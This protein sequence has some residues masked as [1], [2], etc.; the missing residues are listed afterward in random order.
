MKEEALVV[1]NEL[2]SGLQTTHIRN[3]VIRMLLEMG[4]VDDALKVLDEMLDPEA[5]F[6]AD[7]LTVDVVIGLLLRREQIGRSVSEEEIVE[8]VS[9]FGE[10][11]VFPNIVLLTKLVSVLCRNRKVDLA[12]DF[13][14]DVMKMGGAVEAVSC[15]ALLT[16]LGRGNDFERMNA[17]TVKMKE[18]GIKPSVITFGILI[19]RFCKSRRIDAAMEVFVKMSGGIEGISVKPDVIIYNTLIDGQCKVGRQEEG[20]HLME[21]MRLQGGCA[22]NIV[23]YNCLIDGFNK[24]GDIEKGREL[25]DKMKEEGITPNVSTLNTMLDGLCKLGRLNTAF[26]FFNEMQREGMKGNAVT[27]TILITSFCNV[28]N[29]SRAMELFD[30]MLSAGCPTDAIVYHYLICGLSQAGK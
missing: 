7:D 1:F 4:R 24:V 15:N 30:Q 25:F 11:G 18:M 10:L 5:K 12:W 29:I 22:P 21:K 3:V 19:N 20:L 27:Y 6:R 13:L 9:R 28:N 17:L 14:H 8:L 23:T 26:E 16:A 2:D